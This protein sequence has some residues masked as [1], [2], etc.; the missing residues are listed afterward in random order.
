MYMIMTLTLS[1]MKVMRTNEE[2]SKSNQTFFVLQLIKDILVGTVLFIC[3]MFCVA[4]N[5]RY[6]RYSTRYGVIYLPNVFVFM[7][8]NFDIKSFHA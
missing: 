6:V 4:I 5:Q 8:Y 3:P 1:Q 7:T 2:L